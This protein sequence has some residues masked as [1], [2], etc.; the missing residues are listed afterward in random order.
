[1]EK[2]ALQQ[3]LRQIKL[4][5]KLAKD[6]LV[7]AQSHIDDL[8]H[9]LF[10][11]QHQDEVDR[12]HFH[13]V[14]HHLE[15]FERTAMQLEDCR[16]LDEND[17][18]DA[19]FGS[20]VEA[21]ASTL[22]SGHVT[23]VPAA[24]W[25]VVK[26]K[27]TEL[28]K[29]LPL[30]QSFAVFLDDAL[31]ACES[32]A[33]TLSDLCAQFEQAGRGGAARD[34]S[35]LQDVIAYV[36]FACQLQQTVL[37][38][39]PEFVK[40]ARRFHRRVFEV[41]AHWCEVT[42]HDEIPAPPVAIASREVALILANWTRDK[43]KRVSTRQWL[44]QVE[45]IGSAS[46]ELS[47]EL[48]MDGTTL[49]LDDMTVE[50]KQAFLMLIVPILRRNPAVFV[51]V[52]TRLVSPPRSLTRTTIALLEDKRWEMKIHV[53]PSVRPVSSMTSMHPP[54]LSLD[55]AG[56]YAFERSPV[57]PSS[58]SSSSTSSSATSFASARLQIIQERLQRMQSR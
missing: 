28:D 22:S 24:V 35:L 25:S 43:A 48:G 41:M 38:R 7:N 58:V 55:A 3:E 47:A 49:V 15:A 52:F 33:T 46:D 23:F 16:H 18:L 1:M 51:R 10:T 56:S 21:A 13:A 32:N 12:E 34:S 29:F 11:L 26:Q 37:S 57:S 5:A 20:N 9:Q 40:H 17:A 54:V 53:Q 4:S 19:L 30:L 39:D 36:R 31:C 45:A 14:S 50:V 8:E 6:E 27:I 44:E 2:K 42:D